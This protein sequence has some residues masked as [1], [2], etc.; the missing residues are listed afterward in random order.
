MDRE[1][2]FH[3]VVRDQLQEPRQTTPNNPVAV[4]I[5]DPDGRSTNQPAVAVPTP[6]GAYK[7]IFGIFRLLWM[8]FLNNL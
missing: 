4:T 3:V 7:V 1:S 8:F 2:C 6:L 5:V